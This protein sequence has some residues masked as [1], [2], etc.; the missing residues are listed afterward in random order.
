VWGQNDSEVRKAGKA[1]E[2]ISTVKRSFTRT[3]SGNCLLRQNEVSIY[4]Y[5]NEV[6]ENYTGVYSYQ[7]PIIEDGLGNL[8]GTVGSNN[9]IYNSAG[10]VIG[11]ITIAAN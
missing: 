3:C 11:Y 2:S 4:I 7:D 5:V 9:D 8:V 6:P 1:D 10:T